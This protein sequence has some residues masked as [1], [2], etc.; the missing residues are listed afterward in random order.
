MAIIPP[1]AV[2]PSDDSKDL[3]GKT[4][5]LAFTSLESLIN[6]INAKL[7]AFIA[8]GTGG[9]TGGT[10]PA[11]P[12]F[13]TIT[14]AAGHAVVDLANG[15]KQRLVL[16]GTAVILDAPTGGVIVAGQPLD[17]YLDMDATGGR[18]RPTFAAGYAADAS[19]G[20]ASPIAADL[21]TRTAIRWV[22]DGTIWSIDSWRTRGSTT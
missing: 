12:T 4:W 8:A 19:D 21:S 1:Q 9:G 22:Y 13:Y 15:T 6:S 3:F 10:G 2:P 20:D 14:P 7:T 18:A 11:A 16:T 5:W 17:L